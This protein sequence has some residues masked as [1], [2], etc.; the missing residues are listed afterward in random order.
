MAPV[1]PMCAVGEVCAC[2]SDADCAGGFCECA[3]AS[4]AQRICSATPCNCSYGASCDMPLL[5][6]VADPNLC[7]GEAV[8]HGGA[9]LAPA[10]APAP[11][12]SSDVIRTV[13]VTVRTDVLS[14][15]GTSNPVTLCLSA[16]DCFV[17]D[18][19]ETPE[20]Q[21]GQIDSFQ[22][23]VPAGIPRSRLDRVQLAIAP[24]SGT[25]NKWEP[26][27]I[28]VQLDGQPSYCLE[29]APF[30]LGDTT[31][32]VM[33]WSD[34]QWQQRMDCTTCYAETLTHGPLIGAVEPD[35]ARIWV[36]TDVTRRVGLRLSGQPALDAAPVVAWADTAAAADFTA[37]LEAAQLAPGTTYYYGVEI[38]GVLH[39]EPSWS[40]TTPPPRGQPGAFTFAFG[41]CARQEHPQD[42]FGAI[43]QARPDLF[44]FI[45]DNHYGDAT[46]LDAHRWN[47][48]RMRETPR[49]LLHAS[50]PTLA[51]WDDH[52]FLGNDS[53]GTYPGR[54]VARRA[55]REYWPNPSYGEDEQGIY[56]RHSYGDVDFFM[57]DGRFFRDPRDGAIPFGDPEGRRSVLGAPQT[58]WLIE[59]LRAS[60][61][62]FKFLVLGS[63]WT[64]YGNPDSWASFLEARDAI[65]DAIALHR[66]EGVVLLSGDRHRSEYRL[67]PRLDAYNLPELTSSPMANTVREC[68]LEDNDLVYCEGL[69]IL[70]GQSYYQVS[71]VSVD[72]ASED[73]KI[74]ATIQRFTGTGLEPAHPWVIRRADLDF[75]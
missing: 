31:S 24:I 15:S 58:T 44:L 74:S 69:D 71:F 32:S 35:R 64:S 66:I 47:A 30:T 19:A 55:F 33:T 25:V 27:C 41:S 11:P 28:A 38:D 73:P 10:P 68:D 14:T 4:C 51:I 46:Q 22:F 62:T 57:L 40:F 8:C 18:R 13:S 65:F 34:P 53:D 5:D 67:L 2:S 43:A 52:D 21:L 37:T 45:G 42:I 56:F 60:T 26:V 1:E 72:T 63:Q 9:C 29:P 6:G 59:Q 48:Q 7:Q 49:R 23:E 20:L 17:L 70:T 54:E 12:A 50:V 36:R 16:T 75:E 39:S 3:D 61:A